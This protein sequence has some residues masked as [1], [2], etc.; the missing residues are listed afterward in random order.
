MLDSQM[1][2]AHKA[3]SSKGRDEFVLLLRDLVRMFSWCSNSLRQHQKDRPSRRGT[4]RG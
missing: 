2:D 3:W 1:I 4:V